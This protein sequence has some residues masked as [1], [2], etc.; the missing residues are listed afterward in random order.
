MERCVR[1]DVNENE[2]RLFDAI[3][4][5]RM[6]SLCER[7]AIIENI[8]IIK[9]PNTSQLKESEN[10]PTIRKTTPTD[11][12][13][14]FFINNEL[15]ELEQNP[16][17]EQ[18]EEEQLN[19]IEHYHWMIMKNRRRK[20]LTQQQLA[21]ALGESEIAIQ[22]I[23]KNKPP[24]NT[25]RLIKKL[26]QFFQM[27][28]RK[29]T[30]MEK[31]MQEKQKQPLLLN[32][33]GQPIETIPEPEQVFIEP[34]ENEES[35]PT[36]QINSFSESKELERIKQNYPEHHD[37]TND[38]FQQK[39][40]P[41]VKK[42]EVHCK[43]E[44][45]ENSETPLIDNQAVVECKVEPQ[46]DIQNQQQTPQPQQQTQDLDL[47]KINRDKV[48]INQLKDMHRKKVEVTRQERIEEQQKIEERQRIM[49][50]LREQDR[51]KQEQQQQQELQ[52][53]QRQEQQNQQLA[54][55]RKQELE[56]RKKK[57]SQDIDQFLGGS[58]LLGKNNNKRI[59]DSE[60]IDEFDRELI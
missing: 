36:N 8:P 26:E 15:E 9:K 51:I 28:L 32:E 50:A 33:N 4:E 60:S 18:P 45:K 47:R 24:E 58:E 43:V 1:C 48:T 40:Y 39:Y 27:K 14:T 7:C 53:K 13:N 59:E 54:Q 30:E 16:E 34:E 6:D 44:L 42:P 12:E 49:E 56:S 37:E 23:E 55:Q 57:E 2:I 31:Y 38:P 10:N 17:R 20:G 21:K 25:E 29:I 41:I 46:T 3:Y 11:Q 22:M 19:L 35:Q 52:E 5:G